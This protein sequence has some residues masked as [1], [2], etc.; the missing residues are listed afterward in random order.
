[1]PKKKTKKGKKTSKKYKKQHIPKGF[2]RTVLGSKFRQ[3]F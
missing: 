1:M 3:M 2:K